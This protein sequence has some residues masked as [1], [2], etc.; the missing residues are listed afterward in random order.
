MD[1]QT[2]EFFEFLF[3]VSETLNIFKQ[4]AHVWLIGGGKAVTFKTFP[5]SNER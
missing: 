3:N 5:V 1:N 2:Y 4:T